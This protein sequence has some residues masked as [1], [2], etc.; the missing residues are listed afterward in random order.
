MQINFYV[1][2]KEARITVSKPTKW[3]LKYKIVARLIP[4]PLKTRRKVAEMQKL[5]VFKLNLGDM[6]M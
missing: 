5:E 4:I 2:F 3:K 1:A 6:P